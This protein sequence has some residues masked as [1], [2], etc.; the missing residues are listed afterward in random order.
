MPPFHVH[1]AP[2]LCDVVSGAPPTGGCILRPVLA[3]LLAGAATSLAA[4]GTATSGA[5]ADY[6]AAHWTTGQGLPAARIQAI[7]QTR[8]GYLWIGTQQGLARFD[9]LRFEVFDAV[10]TPAFV[11]DDCLTLAE[12]EDGSLWVGTTQ[13]LLVRRNGRFQRQV[14]SGGPREPEVR[15][16]VPAQGG[17]VWVGDV[18][19]LNRVREDGSRSWTARDGLSHNWVYCVSQAPDGT[20]WFGTQ[21][22]LQ[23]LDPLTG[24]VSEDL[25]GPEQRLRYGAQGLLAE[26]ADRVWLYWRLNL[27]QEL[28]LYD[29]GSWRAWPIP[30]PVDLAGYRVWFLRDHLDNLWM[31]A[32]RH[33]LDRFR[34]GVF[35]RFGTAGGLPDEW[36]LASYEDR[37]GGLWI[38]TDAGGL[39]R[40]RRRGLQIIDRR[41][42]LAGDNCWAVIQDADGALWVGADGGVARFG[43]P[44]D[45][46]FT[47]ADG[48]PRDTVRALLPTPDLGMWVGTGGGLCVIREDRVEPRPLPGGLSENKVRALA[49]TPDGWVW[50]G[51]EGGLYRGDGRDWTRLSLGTGPGRRDVRALL[52]DRHGVLWAGTAGAGLV[53]LDGDRPAFF[54][55]K[56]GLSDDTVWALHEGRDGTLWAGTLRGLSW[57]K[58]GRLQALGVSQGLVELPV[59]SVVE[60]LAG[61]LWLGGEQGIY[62]IHRSELEA[63]AAGHADHITPAAYGVSDGLRRPETNGQKSQPAAWRG[64]A[65]ELWFPTVAGLV[66]LEPDELRRPGPPLQ[67]VIESVRVG[68]RDLWHNRALAGSPEA[69][70]GPASWAALPPAASGAPFRVAPGPARL[71]EIQYTAP[72]FE[73]AELTRFRYRL[74]GEDAGWNEVGSRRT[75]YYTRLGPGRYVFRVQACSRDGDWSR[76]DATLA[77]VFE[78]R[79][80]ETLL[81]RAG[82]TIGGLGLLGLALH[83]RMRTRLRLER[84]ERENALARER[85]RIAKDLH[86]AVGANLTAVA[87]HL[88]L[89]RRAPLPPAAGD[90]VARARQVVAETAH[91]MREIIWSTDPKQDTVEATATFLSR[92]V[93]DFLEPAGIRCRF[94]MP[95]AFPDANLSAAVRHQLLLAVKEALT[96]VV[97]HAGATEI[98][99]RLALHQRTLEVEIADN[100]RGL[101]P[102]RR[103]SEGNGL[104]NMR[105]RMESVGGSFTLE[106]GQDGGLRVTL[107]VPVI[108]APRPVAPPGPHPP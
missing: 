78:P 89:A 6:L 81:F 70:G 105:R 76:E 27:H 92:H 48:L 103:G 86:D 39:V 88:E 17:G 66:R 43:G 2:H 62:R 32:G 30:G 7:H 65:G 20:V 84:L 11:S 19:G 83:W 49:R 9:G 28:R 4:P 29:H 45:R 75:A 3:A 60:D 96:N 58:D 94:N 87:S 50:A 10:N 53:R 100:G 101:P 41:D 90:A 68:G 46:T 56:A 61:D 59:N 55:T 77:L 71:L 14:L 82:L 79:I 104:A 26:S 74:D 16:L 37:H 22:G 12:D 21:L 95:P 1:S 15:M 91:T 24:A 73:A 47:E 33:G 42:G 5:A 102:P 34:D 8:D 52:V 23:R 38:G 54:D 44:G 63:V 67:V 97:R 18:S 35:T 108:L 106:S 25:G 85:S 98:R 99:L 69:G 51:T 107:I 64:P 36:V 13:G 40:W 72:S 80:R 31:P 57:L 93:E